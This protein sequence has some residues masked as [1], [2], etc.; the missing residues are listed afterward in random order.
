MADPTLTPLPQILCAGLSVRRGDAPGPC[1]I[2]DTQWDGLVMSAMRSG[3]AS[4][5]LDAIRRGWPDEP[6][7]DTARR[8]LESAR[9]ATAVQNAILLHQLGAVLRACHACAVPVIVL[10]GA[11][12]LGAYYPDV[13]F[14][15]MSDVDIMVRREDLG[16]MDTILLDLGLQRSGDHEKA[17]REHYHVL[18]D[19]GSGARVAHVE[20]HWSILKSRCF[21]IDVE[22][23]WRRARPVTVAGEPALALSPEDSM[24]HLS[25]HATYSHMLRDGL[26]SPYDLAMILEAEGDHLDWAA[27]VRESRSW[28]MD[29]C[30][31]LML[32]LATDLL[33]CR[34]PDAV[35][36]DLSPGVTTEQVVAWAGQRACACLGGQPGALSFHYR[37]WRSGG[38]ES[39]RALVWAVLQATLISM[40]QLSPDAGSTLGQGRLRR[41][42]LRLC[43]IC[44][45]AVCASINFVRGDRTIYTELEAIRLVNWLAGIDARGTAQRR[46]KLG[47]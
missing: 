46:D 15:A 21:P 6:V 24:L 9:L 16:R 29:R 47:I 14:R 12:L 5:A 37:R 23:L 35:M 32:R 38:I 30:L 27:L 40:A 42:A 18:Y 8:R 22:A 20:V 2:A 41:R 36:R 33:G 28:G 45:S 31:Y 11:Y 17:K 4:V 39:R 26:R 25:Y 19:G 43:A 34:V 10:K 13:S 44:R 3:L 7:P 1:P